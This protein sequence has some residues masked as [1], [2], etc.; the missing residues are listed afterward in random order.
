MS[1]LS[2]ANLS[3]RHALRQFLTVAAAGAAAA[4]LAPAAQADVVPFR[5]ITNQPSLIEKLWTEQKNLWR[6]YRKLARRY[7]EQTAKVPDLMPKPHL[8][9]PTA[10]KMTRSA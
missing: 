6:K 5:T 1:E 4:A 8:R 9:S 7:N 10:R 2:K 3:R